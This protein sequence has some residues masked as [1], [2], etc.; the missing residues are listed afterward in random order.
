M[1]VSRLRCL[2]WLCLA[3]MSDSDDLSDPDGY[4]VLSC[5]LRFTVNMM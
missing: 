1:L 3:L 5:S 4:V 2:L